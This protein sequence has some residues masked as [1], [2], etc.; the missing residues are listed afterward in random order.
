MTLISRK[1]VSI[2]S[3]IIAVRFVFTLPCVAGNGTEKL[4]D[5][6]RTGSS[7]KAAMSAAAEAVAL[8]G[9]CVSTC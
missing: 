5:Y 1:S 4:K 3:R 6:S 8:S 2:R 7:K 9:H